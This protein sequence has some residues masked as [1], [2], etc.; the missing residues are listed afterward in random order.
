[1]TA[2]HNPNEP[3]ASKDFRDW[4]QSNGDLTTLMQRSSAETAGYVYDVARRL[5]KEGKPPAP[6]V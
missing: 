3:R 4:W 1:M 5:M 2:V 6:K